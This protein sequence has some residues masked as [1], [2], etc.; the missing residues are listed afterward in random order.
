ME[1]FRDEVIDYGA[2]L[3]QAGVSAELHVWAGAFHGFDLLAPRSAVAMA[4]R[5]AR[6]DYLCRRLGARVRP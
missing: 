3:A 2:R 5:A 1:T 6:L 4:A